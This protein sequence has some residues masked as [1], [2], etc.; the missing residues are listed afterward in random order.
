MGDKQELKHFTAI[1]IES[2]AK[3]ETKDVSWFLITSNQNFPLISVNKG[4][5]TC[6]TYWNFQKL[7]VSLN[8]FP[9]KA[10]IPKE[11]INFNKII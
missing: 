5:L 10:I 3:T 2:H 11:I 9:L 6:A 7:K 1:S 8:C 4:A